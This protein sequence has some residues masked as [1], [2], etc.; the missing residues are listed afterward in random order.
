M[1]RVSEISD[2]L[3]NWKKSETGGRWAATKSM[4]AGEQQKFIPDYELNGNISVVFV[5]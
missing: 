2:T 1:Y 3:Y 5:Q 4:A